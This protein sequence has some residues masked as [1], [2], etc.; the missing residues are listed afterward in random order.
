MQSFETLSEAINYLKSKGYTNDFNL[1]PDWIECAPLNIKIHPQEFH[2]DAVHRF[3][4]M[5]NPDDS[6]VLFAI[7]STSGVKGLLVDAYGAYTESLSSLMVDKLR[8]DRSTYK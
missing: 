7:S 8:V 5:T 3:E 1:H 6:T 4:G 2:V